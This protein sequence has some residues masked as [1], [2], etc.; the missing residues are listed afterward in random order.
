MNTRARYNLFAAIVLTIFTLY[1]L[2]ILFVPGFSFDRKGILLGA[3][4]GA[5]LS[6]GY[7]IGRSLYG[8]NRNIVRL[9]VFLAFSTAGLG[10]YQFLLQR[11]YFDAHYETGN[12]F[13]PE[14]FGAVW[15]FCAAGALLGYIEWRK[16]A[17]Q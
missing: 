17:G 6:F 5:I 7:L 4:Y 15:A 2:A 3:G 13:G 12:A 10:A 14:L 16:E 1:G 9:L 8:K 11:P